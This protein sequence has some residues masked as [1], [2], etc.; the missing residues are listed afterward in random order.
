MGSDLAE[1]WAGED[2]KAPAPHVDLSQPVLAQTLLYQGHYAVLE[3]DKTDSCLPPR[4]QYVGP[5]TWND[6]ASESLV[7]W[8]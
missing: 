6:F 7:Q 4:W 3:E 5:F 8:T 2:R 1:C